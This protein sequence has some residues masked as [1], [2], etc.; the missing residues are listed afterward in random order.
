MT[1]Y[2]L[3]ELNQWSEVGDTV[4]ELGKAWKEQRRVTPEENQQSQQTWIPEIFV[5]HKRCGKISDCLTQTYHCFVSN[6]TEMDY[7][8]TITFLTIIWM[9]SSHISVY[10]QMY[11]HCSRI[12]FSRV[13]LFLFAPFQHNYFTSAHLYMIIIGLLRSH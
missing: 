10:V 5:K 6:I 9:S 11:L 8:I 3:M 7:F 2:K 13:S 12:F 4:I 1:F